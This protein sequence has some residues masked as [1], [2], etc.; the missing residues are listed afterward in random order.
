M[1][2]E[3]FFLIFL[4]IFAGFAEAVDEPDSHVVRACEGSDLKI[5]CNGQGKIE[6]IYANYGRTLSNV[7]PGAYDSN[8]KCTNEKKSLDIVHSSCLDKSS[9]IIKASN[10]VFGDPCVGTYKYLEVK[11]K[12]K[13]QVPIARA[14]EGSDLKI[15]CT[16]KGLI[17]IVDAN[18]GRTVSGVCPG[19]NDLNTKCDY[20]K[21]SLEVIH[22][23]CSAKSSCIITASNAVFGDPCVGTYKYLEVQYRC[24]P[25]VPIARAC[26]GSNLKID[27][28][29]KGLIEIVDAN[30][31]RTVSGVC[32]GANDLNTKCDNKKKSLE[33]INNVCSA[34]SSCIITASNTVFGD[35]CVGTYKYLEVQYRCKPQV[36]I[37]RACE[38][39]DLKIDCNGKGVIEIVDANYGRTVSGVCPGANDLNT[40]CDNKKKSLEIIHNTCSNK[41]SC[42]VKA[43]NNVFGDPCVGTYKYL[44]VQYK[45][46]PQYSVARACEGSDLKIDCNGKGPIQIVDANYGRNL[47]GVCPGANDLNTKC[48]NRKKSL[49]VIHNSCS[50]KCSCTVKATNAVFGDPCIGTYKYLEVQYHCKSKSNVARACEGSDLKIE[51]S[52][53]QKIK[54]I[55]ANYGRTLSNVCPGTQDSNTK[56]NNEKITIELVNKNCSAKSSCTIKASNAVFGDPCVGT[57]K[58]LEVQYSCN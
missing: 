54:I 9:C 31:G 24:K 8:T 32:P 13:P 7:C 23:I 4:V 1:V 57:Y 49:E 58:Y 34:K 12:C 46:K 15:D 40:K 3:H 56:C 50:D 42:T 11:Y 33:V 2:K 47:P 16:G 45:C 35:P 51:C 27:C 20:K 25:Q 52:S 38:G 55:Q 14:C 17:E 29:G 10:T 39:S 53:N 48:D 41:C 26:E 5:D 21:K 18:Y 19:A 6:V 37:A 43:S 30:Y 44:E 28:N 22:N 36:P